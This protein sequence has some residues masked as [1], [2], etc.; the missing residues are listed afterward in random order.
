VIVNMDPKV[1]NVKL[2]NGLEIPILGLGTWKSA[3]GVVAQA[4]KDAIDLGYRHFDCAFVYQ[5]EK[6]VGDGLKAK[7]DEG[8]VK[9]EDLWVTSKLWNVYHRP[10]LV[11]PALEKTLKDLGLKYLDLY[12]IHWPHGAKE[13]DELFPADSTG[14]ALPSDADYVDTWKAMEELVKL[15]LTRSIG[16]SNFNS[17]Q[18]DR[19]L[20]VATIKPVTNQ[21]EVHPYLPQNKLAKFCADRGI[22][23]TAYSPLG[24][25]DRPWAKPDDPSLL[26]EPKV[27]SVAAKYKKTPA[28]VLIRYQIDKGN[29]VIPKSA[30]KSRIA[31]N[32]NVFDFQL[33]KEDLTE[34]DSLDCNGRVV[35]ELHY[36]KHKHYPF[37]IEF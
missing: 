15:G 6:E 8:V 36:N 1:P 31:E 14:Q 10:D 19:V 12:L 3:P 17:Q 18:I 37:D 35:P 27:K 22:V 32:L 34:I 23:L 21:V 5:N 28:Q 24:S 33:T 11:K 7:I 2:N 13:G 16:I 26:E 25:P 9:R 29:V 30:N 20:E 4:V